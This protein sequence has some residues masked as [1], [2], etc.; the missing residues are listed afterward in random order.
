VKEYADGAAETCPE[1]C[2]KVS[3]VSRHF[4]GD[5]D[6]FSRHLTQAEMNQKLKAGEIRQGSFAASR[7]NYLEGFVNVEGMDKPVGIK[8]FQLQVPIR[9]PGVKHRLILV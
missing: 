7:E 9:F 2:D 3:Q 1:L 4:G 5:K 8:I 6:I